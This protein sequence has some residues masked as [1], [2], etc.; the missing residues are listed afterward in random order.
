MNQSSRCLQWFWLRGYTSSLCGWICLPW[1]PL[2]RGGSEGSFMCSLTKMFSIILWFV[3][4]NGLNVELGAWP[5]NVWNAD[6]SWITNSHMCYKQWTAASLWGSFN[7]LGMNILVHVVQG[8]RMKK[9]FP[10][11]KFSA[12]IKHIRY[13]CISNTESKENI[14]MKVFIKYWTASILSAHASCL[15]FS[16]AD[17]LWS[18]SKGVEWF[19]ELVETDLALGASSPRCPDLL[20]EML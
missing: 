5:A 9:Q 4:E 8:I 1:K 10:K 16:P 14:L 7:S 6:A 3:R 18:R 20:S 17:L 12:L 11:V 19:I 13:L 2:S 15:C